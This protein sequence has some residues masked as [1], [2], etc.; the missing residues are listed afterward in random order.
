MLFRNRASEDIRGYCD[1]ID[2]LSRPVESYRRL[3][4]S[5]SCLQG[6]YVKGDDPFAG[7][8]SIA[9]DARA[10]YSILLF[11][12]DTPEKRKAFADGIK[13]IEEATARTQSDE[14]RK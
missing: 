2:N 1:E 8:R 7:F 3:A 12:L 11:T 10:G 9:P 6:F 4:I 14:A 5:A 13:Q